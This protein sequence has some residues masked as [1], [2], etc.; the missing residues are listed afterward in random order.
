MNWFNLAEELW[1]PHAWLIVIIASLYI[2]P[3]I[4]L[5]SIPL[6]FGWHIFMKLNRLFGIWENAVRWPRDIIATAYLIGGIT[7]HIHAFTISENSD[8]IIWSI[9]AA[10]LI[11]SSFTLRAIKRRD[12]RELVEF[13]RQYPLTHP[14]EFFD[15]L[16]CQSGIIRHA[17]PDAPRKIVDPSN[18]DFRKESRQKVMCFSTKIRGIW[19]TM[20]LARM[21]ISTSEG[22]EQEY[23]QEVASG[24]AIIWATR[25]AQLTRAAVSVEGKDLLPGPGT[26]QLFLFTHASFLDFAYAAIALA[27]RPGALAPGS[28]INNLPHFLMA[29]NHFKSNPLL[30]RVL[31]IGKA[32]EALGMIFVD[33]KHVNAPAAIER[34][35]EVAKIASDKLISDNME[36]AI[37]P[38]GSR[39]AP[40]VGAAGQ[41]FDSAY[42]TVGN[43][44]RVAGDAKHLKKGAA[45][46]AYEAALRL[47][48]MKSDSKLEIVPV[49]ITGAGIACPKGSR[50]ILPNVH[51]RLIVGETIPISRSSCRG[52]AEKD[53]PL[54]IERIHGNI[55]A[56]LKSAA[57]THAELER[58]LFEDVLHTLDSLE[59][60][61]LAIAM[62]PWR[63]EDCL[64]HAM[65]DAIYACQ[66][67]RWRALQGELIHSILNFATRDELLELKGRI[68]KLV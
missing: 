44:D 62:K 5:V 37:F 48:K 9:I 57:R 32:A 19:S 11:A 64:V 60:E 15:H 43:K 49:A 68:A 67:K 27:S 13:A 29:R 25:M 52:G 6:R 41:R 53:K 45:Y 14:K 17:L 66:P 40:Y 3:I 42:Y 54:C 34:A 51:I 38:Q 61:E 7:W 35:G 2:V 10:L 24:L 50:R 16:L 46:I 36:I 56:S 20:Q 22:S 31:G 1:Q 23:A 39:A 18:M 59:I 33:R 4:R 21:A 65:L 63:G 47:N 30:Y 12:R 28:T 26:P 8:D 58:R 55:D